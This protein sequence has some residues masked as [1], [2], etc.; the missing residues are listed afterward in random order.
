METYA[1]TKTRKKIAGDSDDE[2]PKTVKKRRSSGSD[3]VV[4]NN[5]SMF[6][7]LRH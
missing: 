6:R 1:E 7:F 2:S 5:I 3:T 4:K